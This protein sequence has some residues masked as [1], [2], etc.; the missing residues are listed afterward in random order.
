MRGTFT[1]QA[2]ATVDNSQWSL[3]MITSLNNLA[4]AAGQKNNT[5]EQL[6]LANRQ[7]TGM[8][9]N[10]QED[11]AKLLSIIQKLAVITELSLGTTAKLIDPRSL[12]IKTKPLNKT[13]WEA[14]KT[15]N[16]GGTKDDGAH[17]QGLLEEQ[18]IK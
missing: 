12:D 5:S 1:T 17:Q 15:I 6:V 7:L 14:V 18:N 8:I 11:N 13:Q 3:Q 2:I 9:T 16:L 4:N 10:F